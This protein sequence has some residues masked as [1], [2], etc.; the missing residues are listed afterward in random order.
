MPPKRAAVPHEVFSKRPSALDKLTGAATDSDTILPQHGD[1]VEPSD[2]D[3]AEKLHRSTVSLHEGNTVKPPDE[4]TVGASRRKRGEVGSEKTTFYLRPDQL[5]KLDELALAYKK[6]TGQ[7][8][9]RQDIVRRLIDRC[10]LQTLVEP[11]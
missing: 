6:Q 11:G 3:T 4:I 2:G 9:D 5:D 1:T 8:I 7:R 10:D